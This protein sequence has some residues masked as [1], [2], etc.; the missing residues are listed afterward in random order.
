MYK[1]LLFL[2][3]LTFILKELIWASLVPLWH[4]PD[5][6]SHFG[7]IAYITEMGK[8]PSSRNN[9]LTLEIL[10]SERLLDTERNEFGVNKFTYHPEYKITF[11]NTYTGP[12]EKEI[13]SFRKNLAYR[14]M[15]KQESTRYPSLYYFIL[16]I[17]YRFFYF[18]DLFIR[19]FIIRI[20]QIIFSTLTIY[21]GYLIGKEIFQKEEVLAISVP[22]LVSFQPMFSFVSAGINSDNI[23]NLFFSLYILITLKIL[24]K[25]TIDL[26]GAVIFI[27]ITILCLY[28]KYQFLIIV[29]ISIFVFV[30]KIIKHNF[31]LKDKLEKVLL[32]LLISFIGY[33]LLYLY[34]WGPITVFMRAL[35]KFNSTSFLA[36]L[37]NYSFL[38]AYHEVLPWYWGIFDWLGVTYPRVIHRVINWLLLLSMIGLIISFIKSFYLYIRRKQKLAW[39]IFSCVYFIF[40]NLFFFLGIYYYDWLEWS[41]RGIHL[42]VQGRYFF[43]LI[44]THI[45]LILF[46]IINLIPQKYINMRINT[47]KIVVVG[48]V[49]FNFYALFI[50]SKTYYDIN[51]LSN[52]IFQMSQYKPWFFKGLFEIGL[53]VTYLLSLFMFLIKYIR[54]PHERKA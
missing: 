21:I 5:E 24:S 43:P 47:A 20:V 10:L 13:Q 49:G 9:D 31:S 30:G 32:F 33:E 4:F 17:I 37:K 14:R 3:L 11:T 6:Q 16:S 2:I 34:R 48:M 29:P 18:N 19:V 44:N 12:F 46:G 39:P 35:T 38:Q 7:Q 54:Y 52:F 22:A 45:V 40:L 8:T 36:Y 27:V 26:K 23:A 1:R 53:M 50:L 41:Q 42:G 51:S 15:V 25:Q 28:I